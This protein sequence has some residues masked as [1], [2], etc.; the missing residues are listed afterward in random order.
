MRAD[1][2]FEVVRQ[3][4]P[5]PVEVDGDSYLL[6]LGHDG[7]LLWYSIEVDPITGKERSREQPCPPASK[8][9]RVLWEM[10]E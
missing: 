7:E 9:A 10:A 6:H 4:D 8:L 3:S 1:P 5:R 2:R